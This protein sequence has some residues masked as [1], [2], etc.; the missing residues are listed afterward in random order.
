MSKVR[1]LP[2]AA[3]LVALLAAAPAAAQGAL[4]S[5]AGRWVGT[6]IAV[7]AGSWPVID[8]GD[9]VVTIS[10]GRR[11]FEASWSAVVPVDGG[12]RW[13]RASTE[14]ERAARPGYYQPDDGADLFEGDPQ[15]WAFAG[16]GELIL[17][18]LQIDEDSGGHLMYVCHLVPSETGMEAMLVLT[19]AGAET[20]R[21]RV[22][23]VRP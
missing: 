1:V 5:Y 22:T 10:G 23:L 20:A 15:Y 7:E 6:A 19:A 3:S 11:S 13:D 8:A 4:E 16:E 18:R 9:F 14:F 17:G 12:A 2:G 21:A